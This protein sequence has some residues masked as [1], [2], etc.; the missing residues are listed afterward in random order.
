MRS[1]HEDDETNESEGAG[2]ATGLLIGAAIG[3]IA[4]ILYAPKSGQEI[5]QDLK[6]LADE[7]T[8]DLKTQWAKTKD[9]ATGFVDNVKEKVDTVANRA[10]DSVDAYADKAID[11][12][13][14]VADKAKGTVDKFKTSDGYSEGL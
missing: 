9:K 14:S 8:G 12:V 7:K 13:I 4:A 6:D 2:F 5:R 1:Y 10:S 3:A 11:T